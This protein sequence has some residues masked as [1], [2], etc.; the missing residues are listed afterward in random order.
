MV[1]I[2]YNTIL[3][4]IILY[5]WSTIIYFSII[6]Y[7][8][9]FF[10]FYCVEKFPMT[11]INWYVILLTGRAPLYFIFL[12]SFHHIFYRRKKIRIFNQTCSS[13]HRAYLIRYKIMFVTEETSFFLTF[14]IIG[15]IDTIFYLKLFIKNKSI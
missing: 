9:L 4:S 3:Y 6:F 14:L 5:I 11:K 2:I 1:I 13:V 10:S 7:F 8:F 15:K 12:N